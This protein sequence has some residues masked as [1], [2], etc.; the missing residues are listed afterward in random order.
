MSQP[1]AG[2]MTVAMP[3]SIFTIAAI[4]LMLYIRKADPPGFDLR[5]FPGSVITDL[6][7]ARRS[8]M[9]RPFTRSVGPLA[10]LPIGLDVIGGVIG[11]TTNV[12]T[13]SI[14]D[15]NLEVSIPVGNKSNLSSIR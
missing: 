15:I 7:R 10:W 11:N 9:V 12:G 6:L 1:L 13:I 2:V 4:P 8:S 3:A 5:L 14:H